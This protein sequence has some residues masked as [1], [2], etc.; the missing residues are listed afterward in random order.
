MI[1]QRVVEILR[2][3]GYQNLKD[4]GQLAALNGGGEKRAPTLASV[5]SKILGTRDE[6][7]RKGV[8]RVG[9]FEELERL[10]EPSP[11]Y[12]ALFLSG[13]DIPEASVGQCATSISPFARWS[14]WR[15]S[16]RTA[17]VKRR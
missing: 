3:K 13:F 14:A 6:E 16:A 4:A 5:V 10:A 15:S 1:Y 7:E 2:T 17:P 9:F 8:A 12:T 11:A